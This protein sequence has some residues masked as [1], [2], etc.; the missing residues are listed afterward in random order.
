MTIILF[1]LILAILVLAHEWGHFVAAR[2]AGVKVEEFGF[3][4]PPRITSVKKGETRYSINWIPLGGF[5][6]IFGEEG[7]PQISPGE[8]SMGEPFYAKP[9]GTRAKIIAAGVA[10][11]VLLAAALLSFGHLLGLPTLIDESNVT[12][13]RDVSIQ[14]TGVAPASPAEETGL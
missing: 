2:Q 9:V 10:M 12:R 13:A 4:F 3:G 7:P 5:V 14:I 8:T 1:I 6:K 11:N